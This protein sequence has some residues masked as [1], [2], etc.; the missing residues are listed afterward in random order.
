LAI[1]FACGALKIPSVEA[2][3]IFL[4]YRPILRSFMRN[5]YS[6]A[7]FPAILADST[8]QSLGSLVR[9]CRIASA[10]NM[11]IFKLAYLR[12]VIAAERSSHCSLMRRKI[13]AHTLW[14]RQAVGAKPFVTTVAPAIGKAICTAGNQGRV[15]RPWKKRR[16][17][18][19]HNRG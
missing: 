10:L 2:F 19:R 18:R 4:F 17:L 14:M 12:R 7:T 1:K 5:A 11:R 15:F 6:R 3:K 8:F 16:A 9:N 13:G